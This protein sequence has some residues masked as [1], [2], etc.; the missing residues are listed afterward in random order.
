MEPSSRRRSVLQWR[1]KDT[2]SSTRGAPIASLMTELE[3]LHPDFVIISGFDSKAGFLEALNAAAEAKGYAFSY[4]TGNGSAD[5]GTRVFGWK[6]AK[7]EAGNVVQQLG[8]PVSNSSTG[9]QP[10]LEI[11]TDNYFVL[12]CGYYSTT[13]TLADY[14]TAVG[15]IFT[16]PRKNF[17]SATF[18]LGADYTK[19]PNSPV[20]ESTYHSDYTEVLPV[21]KQNSGLTEIQA[22]DDLLWTFVGSPYDPFTLR[23]V[24]VTTRTNDTLAGSNPGYFSVFT[25]G[26]EGATSVY[27]K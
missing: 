23:V 1:V 2:N 13:K 8:V 9:Y 18:V 24:S 20:Y 7:F 19:F 27:I 21:Y 14:L 6:S 16:T 25:L 10:L 17:P 11:G 22:G 26:K 15:N 5:G 12:F 4:T 3:A